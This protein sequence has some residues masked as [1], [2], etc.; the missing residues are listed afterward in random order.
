M[1]KTT[2]RSYDEAVKLLKSGEP[3]E[4]E[5]AFNM[6][7]DEF[8]KLAADWCDKGAK[9]KKNESF[10]TISIKKYRIPTNE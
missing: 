4:V 8:F 10:F 5:L 7:T 2:A 9:I 1:I 6:S 3:K